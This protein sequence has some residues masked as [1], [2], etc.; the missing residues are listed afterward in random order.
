[1][2]DKWFPPALP[3]DAGEAARRRA[4]LG[5][6]GELAGVGRVALVRDLPVE[7]CV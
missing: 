7:V 5:E 6:V 1:M 2:L 3:V 4:A